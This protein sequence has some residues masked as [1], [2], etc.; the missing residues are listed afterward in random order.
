M[1]VHSLLKTRQS[2]SSLPAALQGRAL[3]NA[4]IRG[5]T[6]EPRED[7]RVFIGNLRCSRRFES[8]VDLEIRNDHGLFVAQSDQKKV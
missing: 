6:V 5:N 1:R 4:H 8:A 2:V 7:V 3:A